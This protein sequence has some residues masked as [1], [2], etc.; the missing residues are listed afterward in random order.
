MGE[1]KKTRSLGGGKRKNHRG[2][3]KGPTTTRIGEKGG[4]K[5]KSELLEGKLSSTEQVRLKANSGGPSSR[6]KGSRYEQAH[7]SRG[8]GAHHVMR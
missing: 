7:I 2:T 6:K 1:T 5:P 3:L 4:A 8:V